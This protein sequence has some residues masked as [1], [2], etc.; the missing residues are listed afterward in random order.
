MNSF[1]NKP[2]MVESQIEKEQLEGPVGESEVVGQSVCNPFNYT[3]PSSETALSNQSPITSTYNPLNSEIFFD[4]QQKTS[5]NASCSSGNRTPNSALR[6]QTSSIQHQIATFDKPH[7]T[8]YLA[9]SIP[10]QPQIR[11]TFDQKLFELQNEQQTFEAELER[12]KKIKR[13]IASDLRQLVKDQKNSNQSNQSEDKFIRTGQLQNDLEQ[14][15]K[16][17]QQIQRQLEKSK[18]RI[19]EYLHAAHA[20]EFVSPRGF[21]HSQEASQSSSKLSNKK[22]INV[23]DF[24]VKL[25]V[26]INQPAIFT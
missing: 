18:S 17:I 10:I 12:V 6:F 14:S 25:L 7:Q 13:H 3:P 24:T 5:D 8:P 9:T 1:L 20:S 23:K 21:Y 11:S 4:V 2:N 19:K 16:S 15:K 22:K 26:K